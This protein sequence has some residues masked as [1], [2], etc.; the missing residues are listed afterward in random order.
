MIT[1]AVPKRCDTS[2]SLREIQR[3]IVRYHGV[4]GATE[5]AFCAIESALYR[6]IYRV[7]CRTG[8]RRLR[9]V[10]LVC[11]ASHAAACGRRESLTTLLISRYF[12]G[13]TLTSN[14]PR[15]LNSSVNQAFGTFIV[16]FTS[17]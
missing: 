15:T 1:H 8:C 10:E 9:E 14:K 17:N 16:F 11:C 7:S 2:A 6:K 13:L 12:S 3:E 5:S 4:G